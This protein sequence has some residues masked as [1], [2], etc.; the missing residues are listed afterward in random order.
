MKHGDTIF[1]KK[2]VIIIHGINAVEERYT[3]MREFLGEEYDVFYFKYDWKISLEESVNKLILFVGNNAI[4]QAHFIT[5]SFGSIIFRLFYERR[6]CETERVVQIAPL[7]QGS[8][9]LNRVYSIRW[10]GNSL[11][12]IGP[13]EFVDNKNEILSLP[14]P[15]ETGVIAGTKHFDPKSKMGYVIR[16]IINVWESDGKVFIFETKFPGMKD[17]CLVHEHHTFLMMN[18]EVIEKTKKFLAE[19]NF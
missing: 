6:N 8:I 1:I 19:G 14:L 9:L 17:H 5:H 2:T 13:G 7:N 16:F 12:G 4:K 15:P 11:Y 10:I 3:K 18:D